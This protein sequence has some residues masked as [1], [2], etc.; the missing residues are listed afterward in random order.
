MSDEA[1]N[2]DAV[3]EGMN[4]IDLDNT[5]KKK[6]K[7]TKDKDV[8]GE[9]DATPDGSSTQDSAKVEGKSPFDIG[10]TYDYND[11]LER[12]CENMKKNYNPLLTKKTKM[13]IALPQVG[14]LGS[15]KSL[16][17]NF[18]EIISSVD[19]K[20]EHAQNYLGAELSTEVYLND[21]NQLVMKG[22]YNQKQIQNVLK[23]YLKDYVK[24]Q[25]CKSYKTE[26]ERDA[27][28]RIYVLRCK[29]CGASNSVSNIHKGFHNMNRG[30]RRNK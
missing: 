21:K 23:N 8:E 2:E 20:L 9:G 19:R 6:K 24:C 22:R 3:L 29:A 13:S 7:K 11:L 16:W 1:K 26:L 17:A 18:E 4:L 5:K 30:E 12:I 10:T 27:S 14:A 25:N 28:T 15:R